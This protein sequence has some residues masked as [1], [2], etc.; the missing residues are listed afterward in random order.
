[1]SSRLRCVKN[2]RSEPEAASRSNCAKLRLTPAARRP[3][4]STYPSWRRDLLLAPLLSQNERKKRKKSPARY[5]WIWRPQRRFVARKRYFYVRVSAMLKKSCFS[6][7]KTEG[8]SSDE[9]INEEV[10]CE[11]SG[12]RRSSISDTSFVRKIVKL[13]TNMSRGSGAH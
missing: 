11:N 10:A 6:L 3:Y 2:S 12:L 9:C 13:F 4:F 8:P 7:T 5:I 1:M